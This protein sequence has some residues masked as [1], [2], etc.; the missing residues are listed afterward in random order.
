MYRQTQSR[1][2]MRSSR[3]KLILSSNFYFP[4]TAEQNRSFIAQIIEAQENP[5][6]TSNVVN[7]PQFSGLDSRSERF[8]IL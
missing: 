6:G 1:G 3:I 7:I 4:S 2:E 5:L 8:I